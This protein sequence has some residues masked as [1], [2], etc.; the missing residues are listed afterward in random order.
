MVEVW[1]DGASSEEM[2]LERAS[3]G[4]IL[5]QALPL[6]LSP[7]RHEVSSSVHRGLSTMMFCPASGQSDG[8]NQTWTETPEITSW[9]NAFIL[10]VAYVRCL[11]Q[12]QKA[13]NTTCLFWFLFSFCMWGCGLEGLIF[14]ERDRNEFLHWKKCVP[15][16]P[17]TCTFL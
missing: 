13:K 15:P 17:A 2:S 5:P 1:G 9:N 7:S 11:S 4:C 3:E 16:C 14:P 6:S 12:W 10:L 8:V